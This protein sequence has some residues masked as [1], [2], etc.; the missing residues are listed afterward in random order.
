MGKDIANEIIHMVEECRKYGVNE[1][2]VSGLTTRIGWMKQINDINNILKE[3]A[4]SCNF[5]FIDN[6]NIT[7][8]HLNYDGLHLKKKALLFWLIILL[9]HLIIYLSIICIDEKE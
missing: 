7:R 4:S 6:T 8:D 1:V 5:I 9:T 2:F 3:K